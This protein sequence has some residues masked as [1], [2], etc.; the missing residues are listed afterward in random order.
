MK[1]V[2]QTT[3]HIQ[4]IRKNGVVVSWSSATQ[5]L[6]MITLILFVCTRRIRDPQHVLRPAMNV[7]ATTFVSC[8]YN[9]NEWSLWDWYYYIVETCLRAQNACKLAVIV[10][11]HFGLHLLLVNCK[12][13]KLKQ[14]NNEFKKETIFREIWHFAKNRLESLHL[15]PQDTLDPTYC[16]QKSSAEQSCNLQITL[17]LSLHYIENKT[18]LQIWSSS[19]VAIDKLQ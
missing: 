5:V 19:A 15:N 10:D 9:K 3:L 2:D 8:V 17:T 16:K 11:E 7:P 18:M 12:W 4:P 1:F 6:I 14:N 13:V